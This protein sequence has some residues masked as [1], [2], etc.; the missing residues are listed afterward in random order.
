MKVELLATMYNDD[1]LILM[2]LTGINSP[3]TGYSSSMNMQLTKALGKIIVETLCN[4]LPSHNV[5]L[6]NGHRNVLANN[7]VGGE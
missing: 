6:A 2:Y 7:I 1:S 4:T 3:Q 5:V